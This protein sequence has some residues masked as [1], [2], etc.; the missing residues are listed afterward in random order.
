MT[1]EKENNTITGYYSNYK[2]YFVQWHFK[3]RINIKYCN[4]CGEGNGNPLL[5]SCLEN[6]RDREAWGAAI[7]GVAQSQTQLKRLSMLAL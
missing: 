4:D 1:V 3:F 6:P 2:V 7:Y 5:Y